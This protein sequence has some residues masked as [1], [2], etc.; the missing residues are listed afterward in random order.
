MLME[1]KWKESFVGS[2]IDLGLSCDVAMTVL[3]KVMALRE[4]SYQQ[5]YEAAT[6]LKEHNKCSCWRCQGFD[7]DPYAEE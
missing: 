7:K 1:P 4:K 3:K 6:S 2:L 5:G